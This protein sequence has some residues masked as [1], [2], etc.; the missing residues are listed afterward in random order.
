MRYMEATTDYRDEK[1]GELGGLSRV[2][3]LTQDDSHVFCRKDQ[4]KEEIQTLVSIV[5]RL[6]TTVGM[7]KLRARLSYRDDSDK[8]LGDPALWGNGAETD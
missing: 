2:R 1:T 7:N 5:R 4:I 8:Y 3:S 6:Y